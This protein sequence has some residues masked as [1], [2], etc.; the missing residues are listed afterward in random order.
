MLNHKVQLIENI[1][2]LKY[3]LS[4]AALT[5]HMT[6]WAMVL[7]EFDIMYTECKAIKGQVIEDQLV[8][9]P[10]PRDHPIITNFLDETIIT[11]NP[12]I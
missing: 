2:P 4:I 12:N 5:S 6:K 9:D 3:L 10:I 1:D 11:I 8:E 7:S